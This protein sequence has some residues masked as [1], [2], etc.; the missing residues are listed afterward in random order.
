MWLPLRLCE[1][2]ESQS[3]YSRDSREGNTGIGACVGV[4][5]VKQGMD[6]RATRRMLCVFMVFVLRM[7]ERRLTT[8]SSATAEAGA[9]AA[10]AKAAEQPA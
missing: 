5:P 2:G 6:A 9:M 1:A 10:R 3:R 8:P 4:Q 7:C